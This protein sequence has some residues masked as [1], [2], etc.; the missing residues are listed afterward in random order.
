VQS[1]SIVRPFKLHEYPTLFIIN[2]NKNESYFGFTNFLSSVWL[3]F[4]FFFFFFFLG[5]RT[6]IQ[7]FRNFL[8]Q[9]FATPDVAVYYPLGFPISDKPFYELALLSLALEAYN[10]APRPWSFSSR[11]YSYR[12]FSS[13]AANRRM[14]SQLPILRY[15]LVL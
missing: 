10:H 1:N 9:S 3:C 14:P 8:F 12:S 11:V 5:V 2:T 15:A 7:L 4:F 13:R 6:L